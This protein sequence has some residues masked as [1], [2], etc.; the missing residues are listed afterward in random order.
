MSEP[1]K[2]LW[3]HDLVLIG[4]MLVL[5]A[6]GLIYEYLIAHYA[7]RIIGA[8]ETTIYAMIGTMIVAMGVGAFVAKYLKDPYHGFVRLELLIGFLGSLAII[9]MAVTL[10]ISYQLPDQL[11]QIYGL[12]PSIDIAGSLVQIG[13]K[14][15]ITMPFVVGFVL[16]MLIG[17]EIPLV[18]RIRETEYQQHLTHNT[19][20]IYGADYIGAGAGAAIWV[21]ICLQLPVM[22]AATAT[23]AGNLL[24]GIVFLL[25][26][27]KRLTG[28]IWYW[29]AHLLLGIILII[30]LLNGEN[31]VQG[32]NNALF[33]QKVAYATST[34]YQTLTVTERIS[35]KGS[36]AALSL[37]INGRLQFSASDE[38]LYH[39]YLT[40]PAML[41][42][43]RQEHVLIIGGG[44][45]LALRDVLNYPV[46]AVTLVDLDKKMIDL[47]S[48]KDAN[49]PK[50]ISDRLLTLNQS[51]FL[52]KRVEVIIADAFIQ[53]E[54]LIR[55][56]RHFDVIIVDLPDPNHPV[57]NKLYSDYFYTRL[58]ELLNGDGVLAVQSTSPYH[59]KNA[60]LAI[61]NTMQATGLIT[62]QY[63]ANVP[64]FGEWG[65]S[66]GTKLGAAPF[67][68]L[69]SLPGDRFNQAFLSQEAI[70][71]SFVF[72][73]GYF[74]NKEQLGVNSL[75]SHLIYNYHH[76]AWAKQNG[77]FYLNEISLKQ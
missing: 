57:L 13:E 32:L 55:Q 65:W 3:S 34:P 46:K 51:A 25:R 48:G 68:R 16:G 23:A 74:D 8:V 17:A 58:R 63:H 11:Q 72:I 69:Q 26:Y 60:F 45:G 18:A 71:A 53:V 5:A 42:A 15:A 12:H 61:G 66:I 41:A 35:H 44:D 49:A 59:A 47:F 2:I 14:T 27:S 38:K 28:L 6:C 19:G 29:L 52:D 77:V 73:P 70:L 30:L 39:A 4:S 76:N 22:I 43:A 36:P 54:E 75:G 67:T 56:Q 21:L 50:G 24:I 10:F 31:W 40:Q 37:Y 9:I 20:T 62:Q 64:S 7:T 1:R 33:K